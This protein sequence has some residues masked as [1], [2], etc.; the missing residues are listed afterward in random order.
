M[1]TPTVQVLDPAVPPERPARPRRLMLTLAAGLLGLVV[2]SVG[3][4][5]RGETGPRST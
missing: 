4:A 3:L 5:L 1:D 2:A